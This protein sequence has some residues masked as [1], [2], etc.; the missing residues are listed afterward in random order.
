MHTYSAYVRQLENRATIYKLLSWLIQENLPLTLH[1]LAN[2]NK[3][4][5]IML[6]GFDFCRDINHT[7][8]LKAVTR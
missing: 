1:W 2:N 5:K 7:K 6:G 3:A 4:T 8:D